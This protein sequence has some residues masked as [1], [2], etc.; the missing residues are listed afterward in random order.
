MS[1]DH[2]HEWGTARIGPRP[3][4]QCVV[5]GEWKPGEE[6]IVPKVD[7]TPGQV[8]ATVGCLIL[9]AACFGLLWG[10]GQAIGAMFAGGC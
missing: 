6:L 10:V 4:T 3:V 1:R 7:P 9:L 5:C 8:V 2:V